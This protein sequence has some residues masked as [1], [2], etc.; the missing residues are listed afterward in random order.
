MENH[1]GVATAT[2]EVEPMKGGGI[3]WPDH[4]AL[5]ARAVW[6]AVAAGTLLLTIYFVILAVANSADHA[7]EELARLWYW[8]VPL[9]LGFSAQVGLF[10]YARAAT[11]GR[12]GV[13]AHGVMASGG[14]STLSMVACC[15]HHVTDVLPVVG[16]AGAAT[17][18]AAYQGLF[19][20]LGVLSNTVG[21]VYVLG[22]L[23]RHGLY[24]A[25]PSWLSWTLRW[26]FRR[27]LVPVAGG[28]ALVFLT[29]LAGA[30]I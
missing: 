28:A 17:V 27:M 10:A 16:L 12:R 11:R 29:A 3:S 30:A 22:L 26:P 4:V 25:G 19:L 6:W 5:R 1:V 24:P 23:Q 2:P 14:A 9:V 15:A 8:M 18:L 20:L 21:L 7:L 13:H